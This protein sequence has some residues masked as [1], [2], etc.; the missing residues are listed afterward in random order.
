[1]FAL[2]SILSATNTSFR[3]ET[4]SCPF[5]SGPMNSVLRWEMKRK[6]LIMFQIPATWK[7]KSS[8]GTTEQARSEASCR[9]HRRSLCYG[10]QWRQAPSGQTSANSSR[11]AANSAR[12]R[13][14]SRRNGVASNRHTWPDRRACRRLRW[15]ARRT[16]GDRSRDWQVGEQTTTTQNSQNNRITGCTLHLKRNYFKINCWK[17]ASVC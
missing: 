15:S 16:G 2:Y 4:V 17:I 6:A 14:T 12:Y 9:P 3:E 11:I 7:R 13:C 10:A 5:K 1:M 8:S